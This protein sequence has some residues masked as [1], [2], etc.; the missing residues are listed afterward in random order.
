MHRLFVAVDL[1]EHALDAISRI[2]TGISGVKWVDRARLHLTLRFIG[3]ADDSMLDRI[4]RELAGVSAP[5]FCLVPRGVGRFPPKKDPRVLWVGVDQCEGLFSLQRFVEEALRRSGL[6]PE[7]RA[8]TP[9]ITLARL[10][11]VPL[12]KVTSFLE[13]QRL[14]STRPVP[15]VE[16][17]LYSSIL[18][19]RGA[20]HQ[21][22][23]S[24]SL[25]G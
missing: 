10:K 4:R 3:D 9:H 23:A 17:H 15:V 24:Y 13:N 25:Q 2:C 7:S 14:F 1:T 21:R 8:F 16:F 5:P 22:L 18:S 6:Q 19:P 12:S 11:D 20:L